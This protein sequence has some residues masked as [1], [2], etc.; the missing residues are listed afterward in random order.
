MCL[1]RSKSHPAKNNFR[2]MNKNNLNCSFKCN[3]VET[4]IHIFENCKPILS[5]LKAPNPIK[6]SKIF[7]TIED[8]CEVIDTLMNIEAIRKSMKENSYL[9]VHMPGP[10]LLQPQ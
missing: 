7:G 6:L 4:Q 2:K 9:G 10:V 8:Q 5:K 1:L 3:S